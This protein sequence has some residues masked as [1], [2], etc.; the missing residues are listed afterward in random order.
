V[1]KVLKFARIFQL[2]EIDSV[3]LASCSSNKIKFWN[4]LVFCLPL[5]R[6]FHYHEMTPRMLENSLVR[7][8]KISHLRHRETLCLNFHFSFTTFFSFTQPSSKESQS[9]LTHRGLYAS[10]LYTMLWEKVPGQPTIPVG[11]AETR[12]HRSKWLTSSSSPPLSSPTF[13][14]HPPSSFTEWDC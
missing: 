6:A 11:L 3:S 7:N 1:R 8:A 10:L 5:C 14:L 2:A 12:R 4:F 13:R 9:K